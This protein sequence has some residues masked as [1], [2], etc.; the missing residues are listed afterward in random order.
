VVVN[1][2]CVFI[3][4]HTP[5]ISNRTMCGRDVAYVCGNHHD[6]GAR[7]H[8]QLSPNCINLSRWENYSVYAL[9]MLMP[10]MN[11]VCVVLGASL[12]S[13]W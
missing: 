1:V 13:E 8:Q 3:A 7:Y 11:F 4:D 6:A 10:T 5:F 9:V 12:F 2:Q